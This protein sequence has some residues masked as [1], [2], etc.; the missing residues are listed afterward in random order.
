MTAPPASIK[1]KLQEILATREYEIPEGAGFEGTG[2]PGLYLEHLLDLKTSNLD[3][4]DAGA[5]E[6]KFTSGNALL[7]LFHKTGDRGGPT[8]AE[9]IERWGY[10]GKNG[11]PN[12]RT[13]VWAQSQNYSIS[14][15]EGS[16][17]V[18][19]KDDDAISPY[20]SHDALITAFARKL[21]RLIHV[22]GSW[23][24]RT[25]LVT[26]TSAEFLSQARTTQLINFIANGTICIDFDAYLRDSGGVRDHGTKFRIKPGDLH[27]L[28]AT[29]E[30]VE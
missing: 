19:R 17:R 24:R 10:I 13:T 8:V 18:R 28:Y 1:S 20:W 15:E 3:I 6:V 2:A 11:R 16:I 4:P 27:A 21:G 9:I 23:S 26:Y 22:Q 29:R 14:D 25:R 5:W 7:T 12:F 30:A